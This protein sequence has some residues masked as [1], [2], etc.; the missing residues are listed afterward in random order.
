[1]YI[2]W[3][4]SNLQRGPSFIKPPLTLL[5]PRIPCVLN[6]TI[7][8]FQSPMSRIFLLQ[9]RWEFTKPTI[10]QPP[11]PPAVKAR[12]LWLPQGGMHRAMY[13]AGT[14]F[15]KD[16]CHHFCSRSLQHHDCCTAA[17]TYVQCTLY[18]NAKR[19]SIFDFHTYNTQ[20]AYDKKRLRHANLYEGCLYFD[21]VHH[22]LTK[23]CYPSPCARTLALQFM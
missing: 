19:L 20:C 21:T 7:F 23:Q 3:S 10:P 14:R 13:K 2:P 22:I 8:F 15:C 16:Y 11:R 1:M 5:Q 18:M 6:P 9:G 4:P 17:T 12:P